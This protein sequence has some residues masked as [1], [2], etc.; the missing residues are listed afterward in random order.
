MDKLKTYFWMIGGGTVALIVIVT[1]S[2]AGWVTKAQ[3]AEEI[4]SLRAINQAQDGRI[5]RLQDAR[6][7]EN[8]NV[9][10][11]RVGLN[12]TMSYLDSAY[13]ELL[14]IYTNRAFQDVDVEDVKRL[15]AERKQ[16]VYNLHTDFLSDGENK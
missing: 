9:L 13:N 16:E 11:C 7:R 6:D 5:T 15:L 3:S 10:D 12:T 1:A 14:S 2:I 8:Q 4:A